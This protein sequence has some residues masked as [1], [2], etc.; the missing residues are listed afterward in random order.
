MKIR[1]KKEEKTT[2]DLVMKTIG[3]AVICFIL[4][5]FPGLLNIFFLVHGPRKSDGNIEWRRQVRWRQ[6]CD[7]RPL[8]AWSYFITFTCSKVFLSW[9]M[10]KGRGWDTGS[11]RCGTW[12]Y[13]AVCTGLR[14]LTLLYMLGQADVRPGNK[15]LYAL[16]WAGA[17]PGAVAPFTLDQDDI[18]CCT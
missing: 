7:V 2:I 1:W 14:Q 16:D 17:D 18:W 13:I 8:C 5:Y 10:Q 6:G 4:F 15:G 11:S 9:P 3:E 12:C